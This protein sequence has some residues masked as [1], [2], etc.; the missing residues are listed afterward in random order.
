MIEFTGQPGNYCR[1]DPGTFCRAEECMS[2]SEQLLNSP[3]P[4]AQT[5]IIPAQVP[6]EQLTAAYSQWETAMKEFGSLAYD[7][8]AQFPE[9]RSAR[10]FLGEVMQAA[11]F[12]DLAL[13]QFEWL[14]RQAGPAE[15]P[16]IE[17]AMEQC[18]ADHHYFHYFPPPFAK[19]ITS[20]E[21]A[22]GHNAEVWRRYMRSDI[23]R[24]RQIAR[25]LRQWK[26]LRGRRALDVGCGY[27]G[28]M[29]SMAEQGA[30]VT[31]VEID[32]ERARLGRLRL[33]E[34]GIPCD[35]RQ[36]D[37]CK[38]AVR[39]SLGLFD[40]ITCQDV[41]EHVMDPTSMIQTICSML[42][43][44]GLVFVQVPNKWGVRQLMA[45]DH[46]GLTGLTALS[47][48]QAIEY[49][50]MATGVAAPHY[51]VGFP[52]GERYYMNAF[53]RSGV[54]LRH[55]QKYG[56]LAHLA[57][58]AGDVTAMCSRLQ[59]EIHPGLRPELQA[60][61]RRRIVKVLELYAAAC[62][63]IKGWQSSRPADAAEACDR[64]VHRLCTP[65]WRFV[66]VKG[67]G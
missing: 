54:S 53:S 17:Q 12:D 64:I 22:T 13:D 39:E 26:P 56:S 52:R 65:L 25:T 5:E 19:R 11:G 3:V 15:A 48:K 50:Q 38:P 43:P 55:L 59:Q 46:F 58:F 60:R 31:G 24:G 21:F 7:M 66:G 32:P 40:V 16:G 8:V 1:A 57:G 45:D 30:N 35:Y 14:R 63:L 23:Q 36:A 27:G 49:W 37:I 33:E 2:Q 61:V 28:M 62:E 41:L 10:L 47:R 29:I 67:E 18:M 44:G 34:L 42:R 4:S 51:D 20:G 9:D 6:P